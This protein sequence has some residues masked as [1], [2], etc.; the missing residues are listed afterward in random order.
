[1][2]P[3]TNMISRTKAQVCTYLFWI[4]IMTPYKKVPKHPNIYIKC[5][6]NIQI[7]IIKISYLE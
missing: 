3:L 4:N 1:M 6:A 7:N 5:K 2:K